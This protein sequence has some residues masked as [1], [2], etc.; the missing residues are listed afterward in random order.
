MLVLVLRQSPSLVRR[1]VE[2]LCGAR[3]V[4]AQEAQGGYVL[5]ACRQ[6]AISLHEQGEQGRVV[7]V[8][9]KLL[10]PSANLG[11]HST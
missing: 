9:E 11:R 10:Q 6:C 5:L 7:L 1:R 8:I 4:A 3:G 2:G